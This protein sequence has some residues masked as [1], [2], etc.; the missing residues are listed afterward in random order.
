MPASTSEIDALVGISDMLESSQC[1]RLDI[2]Y[3]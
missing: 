2:F 1:C 3:Y